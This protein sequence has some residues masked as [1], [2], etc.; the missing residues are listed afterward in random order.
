MSGGEARDRWFRSPDWDEASRAEFAARM[1]RAH[2]GNRVQYRRIKALALLETRDPIRVAAGR[3]MLQEN[4]RTPDLPSFERTL[5]L[6]SLA[7][8]D[9]ADGRLTSAIELLRDALR[10]AGPDGSGTSGEEEIELAEMLLA[11]GGREELLEA[12]ALLDR[13]ATELPLFVRSRYRLAVAQTR[14]AQLLDD[15]TTASASAATALELA[16]VDHSGMRHHPDLGLVEA[17]A[18]ELAWLQDVRA[19]E[20]ARPFPSADLEHGVAPD[21]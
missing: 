14:V 20:H 18:A 3:A 12:K 6:A 2:P 15:P 21:D 5:A 19:G 8:Q 10:T 16:A 4:L 9:R 11:M 13:R 17:P 7:R 1:K